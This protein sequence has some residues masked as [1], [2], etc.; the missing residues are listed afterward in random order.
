MYGECQMHMHQCQEKIGLF[1]LQ[2]QHILVSY[3][4]LIVS[5]IATDGF[6]HWQ[7]AGTNN[8]D[9]S[10]QV[11][12]T[13]YVLLA[14]LS[15]PPLPG[16]D[17]NYASK[18]VQW[19]VHQQNSQG[20]FS[21]TQDTIVA[22]QALAPYAAQ[23]FKPEGSSTVT[24]SSAKGFQTQFH[25]DQIN[26]LLYQEKVLQEVPGEYTIE[27]KGNMCYIQ[28]YN[29]VFYLVFHIFSY[30]GNRQRTNMVII[31]VKLLS[32]YSV[33]KFSLAM[34][35]FKIQMNASCLFPQ[36]VQKQPMTFTLTIEEEIPVKNIKPATVKI[37]DYYQPSKSLKYAIFIVP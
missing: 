11:E 3:Q 16:F 10:V 31:N 26:R 6:L 29:I 15:G 7:R 14:L 5:P 34:V 37:Y 19:L 20:G 4:V 17:I 33:N 9:L 30:N 21:S 2:H 25:V 32:G 22:L 18:I 36:L 8:N 23:V 12:M 1:S 24:I 13:S 35:R 28:M 27:T